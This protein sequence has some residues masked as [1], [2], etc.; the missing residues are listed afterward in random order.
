MT[1]RVLIA[2]DQDI[3][4]SGLKMILN[5]QPDI[6]VIAEADNGHEAVHLARRLRPDV[7]LFDIRMP[8]MDGIEATRQLAGP[9][10]DDPLAIIIITTYDLDEHVHDALKAGARGFLLKDAGKEL[11]V[12]AIHAAAEGDAL[13]A[14]SITARLLATF[15]QTPTTAP[16]PQPIDSLT[17]REEEVLATVARGRTNAEIA[18][19]L[20][21]SL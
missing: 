19:E 1:I 6:D 7:C 17:D 9:D 4:R 8:L 14:P 11:L 5:G 18:E 2:D 12:Q 3:I 13:I 15:S 20:H 21:I 10:V 16:P